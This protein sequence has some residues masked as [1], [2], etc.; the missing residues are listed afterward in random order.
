MHIIFNQNN[1]IMTKLLNHNVK[2]TDTTS[3]YFKIISCTLGVKTNAINYSMCFLNTIFIF[4]LSFIDNFWIV[5]E[6]N[7]TYNT[8]DAD[9][10]YVNIEEHCSW[11]KHLNMNYVY[12]FCHFS[13]YRIAD[14]LF[15]HHFQLAGHE[16][17]P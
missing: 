9:L 13:G 15:L 6:Y 10:M 3:F 17:T 1:T 5:N 2:I 16:I 4:I 12:L 14:Y 11:W 7:M 8:F